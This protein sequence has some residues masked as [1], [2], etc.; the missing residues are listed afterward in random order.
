MKLSRKK[1]T[2]WQTLLLFAGGVLVL[3]AASRKN[4]QVQYLVD[5]VASVIPAG[6]M[7]PKSPVLVS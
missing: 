3:I 5:K 7:P 1:G 4:Q 6:G 2:D